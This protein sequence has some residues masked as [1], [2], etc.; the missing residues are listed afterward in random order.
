M[1]KYFYLFAL[2]ITPYISVAQENPSPLGFRGGVNISSFFIGEMGINMELYKENNALTFSLAYNI[3]NKGDWATNYDFNSSTYAFLAMHGPVIRLG[4]KMSSNSNYSKLPFFF[5]PELMYRQAGYNHIT[6]IRK[7]DKDYV[8][9]IES[10][11][12]NRYGGGLKVGWNKYFGT[13]Q[14][15]WELNFGVGTLYRIDKKVL[16]YSNNITDK[17]IQ[18]LYTEEGWIFTYSVNFIIG[19]DFSKK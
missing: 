9:Q 4:Y 6:F 5:M 1:K 2:I 14:M 15:Y 12:S 17:P 7:S 3:S 18:K 10:M 13:S 19:L 16:H 11:C 8:E